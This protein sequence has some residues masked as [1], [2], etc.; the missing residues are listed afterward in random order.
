MYGTTSVLCMIVLRILLLLI[1]SSF[2]P[3]T[4]AQSVF[5]VDKQDYC[6]ALD[7]QTRPNMDVDTKGHVTDDHM[8]ED[9]DECSGGEEHEEDDMLAYHLEEEMQVG[10]LSANRVQYFIDCNCVFSLK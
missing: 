2:V 9:S 5:G 8:T 7:Q 4:E 1:Y 3:D 6:V 10:A